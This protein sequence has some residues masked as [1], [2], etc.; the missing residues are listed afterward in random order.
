MLHSGSAASTMTVSKV[1]TSHSCFD[2]RESQMRRRHP[3]Y[4]L[5]K[6]AFDEAIVGWAWPSVP[7]Q[8]T[9]PMMH[10]G[11]VPGKCSSHPCPCHLQMTAETSGSGSSGSNLHRR[12]R[13][14]RSFASRSRMSGEMWTGGLAS[15]HRHR[16]KFW[17]R[18]A[19]A[20][21][22]WIWH[23][24]FGQHVL[25]QNQPKLIR[26]GKR[27]SLH[28]KACYAQGWQMR[29]NSCMAA[30]VGARCRQDGHTCTG[31]E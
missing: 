14:S 13:P 4:P 8:L 31:A 19:F 30:D 27:G 15:P 5:H 12:L 7:K 21:V 1:V 23:V 26:C 22:A 20:D 17:T 9:Q 3:V 18:Q 11:A 6:G 16:L 10:A 29:G 28:C 25:D 2:V 24:P